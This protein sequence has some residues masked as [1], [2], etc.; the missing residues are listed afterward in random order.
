MG[1]STIDTST[2]VSTMLN[3]TNLSF[4][5]F[6]P[7]FVFLGGLLLALLLFEVLIRIFTGH[8]S[9]AVDDNEGIGW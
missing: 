8:S 6:E 4:S 5:T 1:T 2:I 7:L 9:G 3:G